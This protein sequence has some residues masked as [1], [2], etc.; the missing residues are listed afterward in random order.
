M[1]DT[2]DPTAW[3]CECTDRYWLITGTRHLGDLAAL[4]CADCNQ[5]MNP[6]RP[7]GGHPKPTDRVAEAF[8]NMQGAVMPA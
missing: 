3:I 8:R 1:P 7:A 6:Y 5:I 2:F 4:L